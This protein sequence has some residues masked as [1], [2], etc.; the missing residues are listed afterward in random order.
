MIC[1][2]QTVFEQVSYCWTPQS[3]RLRDLQEQ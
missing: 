3:H 1:T 2:G